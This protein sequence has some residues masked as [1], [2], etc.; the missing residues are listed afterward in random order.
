MSTDVYEHPRGFMVTRFCGPALL[1]PKA[2]RRMW[3]FTL[4]GISEGR[5]Y[6]ALTADETRHLV[7]RLEKSL[8]RG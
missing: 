4:H 3:Q 6:I 7:A 2:D 1:D 8:A 5:G